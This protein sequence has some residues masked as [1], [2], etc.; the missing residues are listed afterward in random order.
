MPWPR[1]CHLGDRGTPGWRIEESQETEIL[2]KV[3][4]TDSKAAFTVFI[5]TLRGNCEIPIACIYLTIVLN[6]VE[7]NYGGLEFEG[8]ATSSVFPCESCS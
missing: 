7:N 3:N 5:Y 6:M 4:F 2:I 8:E 1:T